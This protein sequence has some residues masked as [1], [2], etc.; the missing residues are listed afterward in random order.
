MKAMAIATLAALVIL[1]APPAKAFEF[2]VDC[3]S[4]NFKFLDPAYNIDCETV[5]S[6]DGGGSADVMSVTDQERTI[7]FTMVERRITGQPHVFL[8]YRKLR[9]NF[10]AMFKKDGITDWRSLDRKDDYEVAEFSWDM[11]GRD[12]RCIAVQRY[13]N[14]MYTGYKRHLFGVGCTVGDL[15]S[16]YQ[17]LQRIDGD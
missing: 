2:A 6:L 8:Q 16:V 14:P 7:F 5:V 3:S 4:T 15:P 1:C 9:E 17:L 13:T 11:S 10:D 12:S